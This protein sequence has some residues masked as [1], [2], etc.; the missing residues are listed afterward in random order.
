[1]DISD[2]KAP[3]HSYEDIRTLTEGILARFNPSGDFPIDIDLIIEKCYG[4][5]IIP[6]DLKFSYG[7]EAYTSFDA[8]EI[9]IDNE[10]AS[11]YYYRY[12]FSLAHELGHIVLHNDLLS[13]YEYSGV[14]EYI[15]LQTLLPEDQVR[16]LEIQANS[17]AA[18][19][20]VPDSI[21]EEKVKESMSKFIQSAGI[22]VTKKILN[23]G[24]LYE[25]ATDRISRTIGDQLIVSQKTV[26][27]RID[28][29]GI[30]L[31]SYL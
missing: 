17:F 29:N 16:Y 1:M 2:F 3:Y 11:K 14:D 8:K 26:K 9:R 24:M 20:L 23:N 28:K 21:L 12:R 19:L 27:Y 4:I 15:D 22:D 6:V 18:L 13:D 7:I 25:D 31:N 10:H 30:D 5:D